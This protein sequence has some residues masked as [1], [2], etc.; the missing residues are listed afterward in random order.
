[1]KFVV[2][3][4]QG[5]NIPEF[6]PKEL[7]IYDGRK[8]KSYI[9]KPI[10]PLKDLSLDCRRQV[11]YLFFNH[12]GINYNS[13][14]TNYED[15]YQIL[16]EDLRDIDRIYV[17]GH[18]KENFLKKIFNEMKITTPYIVN[19]ESVIASNIPKLDK[20]IVN[21]SYH[22]LDVCM[23]SVKNAYVLYEFLENLLP[24]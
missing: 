9:F 7:A 23:C 24:Q 13:G 6:F 17:K 19:L 18:V 22:S 2:V 14:E 16:L 20:G 3:D 5:F 11:G 15:I 4:A 1:M 10:L 8:M 12:H 21:C